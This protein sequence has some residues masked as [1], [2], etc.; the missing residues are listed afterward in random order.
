MKAFNEKVILR[1]VAIDP[2]GGGKDLIA[3]I[4]TPVTV[5]DTGTTNKPD[6]FDLDD[7]AISNP[8]NTDIK[9]NVVFKVADGIYDIVG[10]SGTPNETRWDQ[11]EIIALSIKN[12]NHTSNFDTLAQAIASTDTDIIFDGAVLKIKD[13]S[14]SY[15]DVVLSSTVTEDEKNIIQLTGIPTLSIIVRGNAPFDSVASMIIV[16]DAGNIPVGNTVK[17]IGYFG[18]WAATVNKSTGGND[19]E[20]VDAGSVGARPAADGGSVIHVVG[21][22]G[23]LYMKGLFIDDVITITQ[24]GAVGDGVTNDQPTTQKAVDYAITNQIGGLYVPG[25]TFLMFDP[26]VINVTGADL[27]IYGNGW[28]AGSRFEGNDLN[29]NV[30]EITTASTGVQTEIALMEIKGKALGGG[31]GRGVFIS[32]PQS[33]TLQ[34]LWITTM[35]GYGIWMEN[36]SDVYVRRCDIEFTV[37]G[38]RMDGVSFC[39]IQA[40]VYFSNGASLFGTDV[41]RSSIDIQCVDGNAEGVKIDTT[42]TGSTDLDIKAIVRGTVSASGI[43][44]K[45]KR[46][47]LTNSHVINANKNGV[48]IFDS[49]DINVNNVTIIN[50]N[51]AA[52]SFSGLAMTGTKN[53]NITNVTASDDQT[54]VETQVNGVHINGGAN[55]DINVSHISGSGNTGSLL[56]DTGTRTVVDGVGRAT[57]TQL[58]DVTDPINTDKKNA[59]KDVINTTTSRRIYASGNG[60]SAN[61]NFMDGTVAHTP[62]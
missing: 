5:F 1:N 35:P 29:K 28:R 30:I 47:N 34:G 53:S 13:R 41:V 42:T 7:V 10:A 55:T 18:G 23:G 4:N 32:G 17:T 27:R 60:A 24:W 36:A 16:S 22:S 59:G 3:A 43:Q 12:L 52:T 62:V 38:I 14:G 40:A 2:Q 26:V 11:V 39:E 21:G 46:I 19:Y 54:G 15:W 56:V 8:V 61:W 57:T 33:V 9:G 20:L 31:T 25:L 48:F 37:G 58:A 50:S 49:E 45:G 6:L 44:I 51:Q